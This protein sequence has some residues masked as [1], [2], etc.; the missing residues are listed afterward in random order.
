MIVPTRWWVEASGCLE[1]EKDWEENI[2]TSLKKYYTGERE[3][4]GKL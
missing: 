3:P 2:G 4:K 1:T